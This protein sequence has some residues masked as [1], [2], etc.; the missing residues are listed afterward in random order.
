MDIL[1]HIAVKLIYIYIISLQYNIIVISYKIIPYCIVL[2][3]TMLRYALVYL[4]HS[5]LYIV[6]YFL[7]TLNHFLPYGMIFGYTLS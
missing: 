3:Y 7:Y 2:G 4:C 1:K 5:I 6:F